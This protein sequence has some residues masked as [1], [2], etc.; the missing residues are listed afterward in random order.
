[1]SRARAIRVR[2]RGVRESSRCS[3]WR[4]PEARDRPLTDRSCVS[5]FAPQVYARDTTSRLCARSALTASVFP[6][7]RA[8]A[9]ANTRGLSK[10]SALSETTARD[11]H[12]MRPRTHEPAA[13]NSRLERP[14]LTAA[15]V[16]PSGSSMRGSRPR[17]RPPRTCRRPALS[18]RTSACR[19]SDKCGTCPWC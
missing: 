13:L 18:C 8:P 12:D 3:D 2:R 19:D 17:Q 11:E 15:S 16:V 4:S 10:G 1:M 5:D 7:R 9:P 6:R 14:Q